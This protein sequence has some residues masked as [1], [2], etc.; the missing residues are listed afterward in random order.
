MVYSD[1][2]VEVSVTPE[3][4]AKTQSIIAE[5]KDALRS[6]LTLSKLHL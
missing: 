1:K 6:G 4:W 2:E 3:K 5:L